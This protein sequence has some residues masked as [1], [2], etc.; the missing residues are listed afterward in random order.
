MSQSLHMLPV[1]E[2]FIEAVSSARAGAS[3][4]SEQKELIVKEADRLPF[5]W[6]RTA[7][8]KTKKQS[9][10]LL[11][12]LAQ[13]GVLLLLE[14]VNDSLHEKRSPFQEYLQQKFTDF[15]G[16]LQKNYSSYFNTKSRM[17]LNMWRAV[18][19]QTD[20]IL[21]TD[22]DS[23][24]LLA[25]SELVELLR[26]RYLVS[27]GPHVPSFATANYWL[28]VTEQLKGLPPCDDMTL[29]MIY[30]LVSYNF[31]SG[32]FVS[33][34]LHRYAN[35]M[36]QSDTAAHWAR[37]IQQVNRI[38]DVHGICY[39]ADA[40][41]CKELLL[42]GITEEI[43][44][45]GFIDKVL[46][47]ATSADTRVIHTNLT[48]T[49]LAGLIRLMVDA[50]I[51]E[52]D[53]H[54]QLMKYIANSFTSRNRY[55]FTGDSLRQKYYQQDTAAVSILKTHLANMMAQLTKY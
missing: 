33:Y 45:L 47:D 10:H 12:H 39:D 52:C 44:A 1:H 31:N 2:P 36:P 13:E 50:G 24:L 29:R 43:N 28:T 40:A 49:Q 54:A 17:P 14:L 30:L 8:Q 4:S 25:D 20:C 7:W 32:V 3:L 9:M 5:Q 26:Q 21:E 38:A 18:K 42:A 6:L 11:V 16:Y 34:L 35:A 48:V 22:T 53:N 46:S 23:P 27:T 55:A 15:I 37:H 19:Q 41:S 51:L